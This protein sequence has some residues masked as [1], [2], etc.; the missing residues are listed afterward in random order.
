MARIAKLPTIW[1]GASDFWLSYFEYHQI[2]LNIF[3]Y[4]R[5]PLAQHHTIEKKKALTV[6][7]LC[8][9]ST[10]SSI[11]SQKKRENNRRFKNL[12]DPICICFSFNFLKRLV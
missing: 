7:T 12:C 4:G 3:I 5:S 1:R 8:T 11:I 6:T 9:L 2:W 10:H